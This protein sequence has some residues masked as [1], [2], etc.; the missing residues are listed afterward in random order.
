MILKRYLGRGEKF[1]NNFLR[2]GGRQEIPVRMRK[3]IREIQELL[4]RAAT[5]S[6]ELAYSIFWTSQGNSICRYHQK[7]RGHKQH[8]GEHTGAAPYIVQGPAYSKSLKG[9]A[10]PGHMHCGCSIDVVLMDFFFWKTWSVR[11]THPDFEEVEESM[12]DE[13]FPAR[14]RS[15]VVQAYAIGTALE[16]D[17][18]YAINYGTEYG[19]DEYNKGV[20]KRQV[21]KLITLLDEGR[22]HDELHE[23]WALVKVPDPEFGMGA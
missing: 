2:T 18:L 14:M 12:R 5:T 11:S 3:K 17:D 9:T 23:K 6:K 13:V 20:R 10:S 16:L 19:T 4:P 8:D 15:F 22:D 21:E 1:I 7:F